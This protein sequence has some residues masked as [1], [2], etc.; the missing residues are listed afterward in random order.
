MHS[1]VFALLSLGCT[2]HC[3]T[4][5][6]GGTF[7]HL[8][9][10][11]LESRNYHGWRDALQR[12][13]YRDLEYNRRTGFAF[14]RERQTAM[15]TLGPNVQLE[16]Y[17]WLSVYSLFTY[18]RV[19]PTH[20]YSQ[21]RDN[22]TEFQGHAS[23]RTTLVTSSIPTWI[24]PAS[25]KTAWIR[26][27]GCKL[28]D[29]ASSSTARP[30]CKPCSAFKLDLR[31]SDQMLHYFW[32]RKSNHLQGQLTLNWWTRNWPGIRY[33][34]N[35][36]DPLAVSSTLRT[37]SILGGIIEIPP[38]ATTYS[39]R[40]VKLATE[41]APTMRE[42]I[43][44]YSAHGVVPAFQK[45]HALEY[46]YSVSSHRQWGWARCRVLSHPNGCVCLWRGRRVQRQIQSYASIH[47]RNRASTPFSSE[48]ALET[49]F[50]I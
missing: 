42:C 9:R 8:L 19:F 37:S 21:I 43:E 46:R 50:L 36:F 17:G 49:R 40:I 47:S 38:D 20:S 41:R 33:L 32:A 29:A 44:S 13:N 22:W 30:K 31:G 27:F 18:R 45:T 26:T 28:R 25:S 4:L 48:Q 11:H 7:H 24:S 3:A 6:R 34:R 5:L 23:F 14:N 16:S 12:H 39:E 15:R 1:H 10:E 35:Y 2:A